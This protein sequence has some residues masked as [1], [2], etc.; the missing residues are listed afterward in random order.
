MNLVCQVGDVD[1]AIRPNEKDGLFNI[2]GITTTLYCL[3]RH[4]D[5]INRKGEWFTAHHELIAYI[6]IFRIMIISS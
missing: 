4:K 3:T 2:F 6:T 1:Y 5:V